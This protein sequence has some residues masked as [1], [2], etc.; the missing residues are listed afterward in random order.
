VLPPP[1][2]LS[3]P[4]VQLTVAGELGPVLRSALMPHL[5]ARQQ[6]CTVLRLVTGANVDVAALVA[7]LDSMGLHVAS[8]RRVE[9][10]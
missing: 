8:V 1:A 5:A 10:G 7:T 4:E 6:Q 9:G 2:P 3:A